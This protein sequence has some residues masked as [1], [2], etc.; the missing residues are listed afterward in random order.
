ML[1]G[2]A[3][4]SAVRRDLRR[5]AQTAVNARLPQPEW[6]RG[7]QVRLNVERAVRLII[8]GSAR[9]H[10]SGDLLDLIHVDIPF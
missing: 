10:I 5:E 4:D 2:K 6:R 1:L 9:E 8:V 7:P 3:V